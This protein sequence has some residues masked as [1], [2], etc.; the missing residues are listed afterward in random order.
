MNLSCEWDGLQVNVDMRRG[1]HDNTNVDSGNNHNYDDGHKFYVRG[2]QS[3][4]I[5]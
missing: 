2:S 3:I 1:W 5:F 4:F